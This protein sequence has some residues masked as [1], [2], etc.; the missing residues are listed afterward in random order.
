VLAVLYLIDGHG[1]D[2]PLPLLAGELSKEPRRANNSESL[3]ARWSVADIYGS[4]W[5]N[6]QSNQPCSHQQ[7]SATAL[8][9]SL[10]QHR[11]K[12]CCG[13]MVGGYSARRND[14][15]ACKHDGRVRQINLVENYRPD[16]SQLKEPPPV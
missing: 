4:N 12:I 6:F 11:T 14:R 3:A 16:A 9:V 15:H 2:Y 7:Q 1:G 8:L 10:Y 5:A 13:S